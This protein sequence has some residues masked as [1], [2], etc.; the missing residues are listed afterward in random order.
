MLSPTQ[1][2]WL[3]L[4][5]IAAALL[6]GWVIHGYIRERQRMREELHQLQIQTQPVACPR[7]HTPLRIEILGLPETTTPACRFVCPVCGAFTYPGDPLW[8][9]PASAETTPREHHLR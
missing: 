8:H 7:G 9:W 3:I 6:L 2:R 4:Q 1:R 5:V